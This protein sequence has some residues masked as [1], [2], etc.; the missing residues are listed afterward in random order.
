VSVDMTACQPTLLSMMSGDKGLFNDCQEDVFYSKIGEELGVDRDGA[1]QLYCVY[2]FGKN[3]Y[4]GDKNKNALLVQRFIN[5]EYPKAHQF[6]WNQKKN[7]HYKKFSHKLQSYEAEIF[8]DGIMEEL[9]RRGVWATSIHDGI[10]GKSSDLEEI[11]A[12]FNNITG[13]FSKK[14][15]NYKVDHMW[16]SRV[17]WGLNMRA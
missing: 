4:A 8:I 13:K 14:S 5:K 3:R 9:D 7:N 12:V 15:V 2:N 10:C 6:A 16:N 17:M 11:I 1:K